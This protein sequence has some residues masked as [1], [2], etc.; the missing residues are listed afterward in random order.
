MQQQ[1]RYAPNSPNIL[2]CEIILQDLRS[3][4]RD[5]FD[6][7]THILI[8]LVMQNYDVFRQQTLERVLWLTESLMGKSVP[9]L[10]ELVLCLI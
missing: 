5:N 6:F 1:K 3:V 4:V 2:P 10:K 9:K 7:A 8:N